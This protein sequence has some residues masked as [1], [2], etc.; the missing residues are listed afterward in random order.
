[1]ELTYRWIYDQMTKG[2]PA[3]RK[4]RTPRTGTSISGMNACP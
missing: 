1:L 4:T 2:L 3:S